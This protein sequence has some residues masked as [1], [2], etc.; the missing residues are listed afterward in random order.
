MTEFK[1]R[2]LN[3]NWQ[4]SNYPF[5]ICMT[6]IVRETNFWK[7]FLYHDGT[8]AMVPDIADYVMWDGQTKMRE[9]RSLKDSAST[10]LTTMLMHADS[11]QGC[12]VHC[13][14]E[15]LEKK[16]IDRVYI[17][18]SN[19]SFSTRIS[20]PEYP[21]SY[22]LSYDGKWLVSEWKSNVAFVDTQEP[23]NRMRYESLLGVNAICAAHHSSLFAIWHIRNFSLC[24]SFKM[25]KKNGV[26]EDV[27]FVK[28]PSMERKKF[29]FI[30]F[31]PDDDSL[32]LYGDN[33]LI[34]IDI[35][36]S[37]MSK[38]FVCCE[39]LD[40]INP[41]RK[42]FFSP[43]SAKLLVAL[44]DG[45]LLC[46]SDFFKKPTFGLCNYDQYNPTWRYEDVADIDNQA[47][48]I[49]WGDN[50]LLF[51]LDPAS[52]T[53]SKICTLVA[54]NASTGRFLTAYKF[55]PHNPIAMGLVKDQREI[56]FVHNNGKTTEMS[57]YG[58]CNY[59]EMDFIENKANLYE[60]CCLWQ[61]CKDKEVA[62]DQAD[63]QNDKNVQKFVERMRIMI[64][65]LNLY[66]E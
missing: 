47:P 14:S 60:L 58:H 57:L 41:I 13:T 36:D 6:R 28:I 54:Y 56:V 30:Q 50:D 35:S 59:S 33:D 25:P 32:C 62:V 4:Y 26:L 17:E 44:K 40:S 5:Q 9:T 48:C 31:S 53:D 37:K 27:A 39:T 20:Y 16:N 29:K 23:E 15:Q 10:K 3:Y 1:Q 24:L 43:D 46:G 49:L 8:Y 19:E 38:K 65:R 45:K 18:L 51:S 2:L 66:G 52:H 64:Y 7:P 55:F 22:V 12:N 34:I 42:V 11:Q 21:R 63:S 61:I